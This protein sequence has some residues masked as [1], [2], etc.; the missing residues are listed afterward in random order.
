[1]RSTKWISVLT[2]YCILHTITAV[3]SRKGKQERDIEL[4]SKFSPG[5]AERRKIKDLPDY[6]S[7]ENGFENTS[8]YNS[9]KQDK[10]KGKKKYSFRNKN[11]YESGESITDKKYYKRKNK[12]EENLDFKKKYRT[13]SKRG[14]ENEDSHS[15]EQFVKKEKKFKSL[16]NGRKS[17]DI[18]SEFPSNKFKRS[19]GNRNGGGNGG[20]K[21]H[22][23]DEKNSKQLKKGANKLK[24]PLEI[25]VRQNETKVSNPKGE[26]NKT[27]INNKQRNGGYCNNHQVQVNGCDDDSSDTTHNAN[28]ETEEEEI[29]GSK[30]V[31]YSIKFAHEKKSKKQKNKEAENILKLHRK[32]ESNHN[33]VKVLKTTDRYHDT[34][35][36][37]SEEVLPKRRLNLYEDEE[38]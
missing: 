35:E 15:S 18:S 2:I 28:A 26:Y 8:A 23:D 20:L 14:E 3:E 24:D 4:I 16:K 33:N 13:N 21:F 9:Q 30:K 12:K 10:L 34:D 5:K 31:K 7:N 32:A 6:S 36:D 29:V 38:G 19:N 22:D 37:S 17:M 27:S 25:R 11:S 1:M